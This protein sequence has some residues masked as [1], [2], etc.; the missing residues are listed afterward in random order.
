MLTSSQHRQR[1][2][3]VQRR[4]AMVL[5]AARVFAEHGYEQT[6][7]PD[8]AERLDMGVG[9]LYHYFGGKEQL[10]IEICNQ[11]MEP[12]LAKTEQHDGSR[13]AVEQLSELL[14]TWVSHVVDH[15]DHML[16]F[17]QVR[18]L[19]DA[20]HQWRGVRSSR[21]RF[22][23]R[24]DGLLAAVERD[25]CLHGADRKL[26]L[27]ALLGMVNHTAQWYRSRGQLSPDAI[28][29]GYLQLVTSAL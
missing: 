17:Q 19:I 2:R 27:R 22:E 15:R 3:Y 9:S 4:G 7:V 23:Q 16:V 5:A 8:L 18:H 12:L 20:E 14:S 21:K 13:D 11:L 10:L 6:S 1:E 28:A 26:T 29:R 24:V 25:G